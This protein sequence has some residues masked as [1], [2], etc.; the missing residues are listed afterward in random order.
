MVDDD[1]EADG[2]TFA[3]MIEAV[4]GHRNVVLAPSITRGS[5]VVNVALE[6]P[7]EWRELSSGARLV[8]CVA[9]GFGIVAMSGE[10]MRHLV[11]LH[12]KLHFLDD[13]NARKAALFFDL[14]EPDG[15][16][17]MSDPGVGENTWLGEDASFCRRA[18]GAGVRLE[19]LCNGITSHAGQVLRLETVAELPTVQ[20]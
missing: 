1:C 3:Q 2:Y 12:P 20:K 16:F 13:D 4:I 6:V 9:G 7:H 19:A 18:T 10:T 14:L 17:D 5:N 11:E 15:S 8:R